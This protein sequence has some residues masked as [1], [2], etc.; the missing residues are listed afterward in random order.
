MYCKSPCGISKQNIV[1]IEDAADKS[2]YFLLKVLV[3]A[4]IWLSFLFAGKEEVGEE[5]DRAPWRNRIE[6]V[7]I[8]LFSA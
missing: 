8:G 6:D 4:I 1:K 5:V 2:V 7:V 3:C